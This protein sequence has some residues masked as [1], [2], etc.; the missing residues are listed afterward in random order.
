MIF[1]FV[2]ELELTVQI[3]KDTDIDVIGE[4]VIDRIRQHNLI[5][6]IFLARKVGELIS[7][8]SLHG[9]RCGDKEVSVA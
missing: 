4:P 1:N 6:V 7:C 2:A 9:I 8:W 5:K 3:A